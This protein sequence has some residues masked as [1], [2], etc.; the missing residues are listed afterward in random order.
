MKLN[1]HQKKRKITSNPYLTTE[2]NDNNDDW[3]KG[4][5]TTNDDTI[6]KEEQHKNELI[7]YFANIDFMIENESFDNNE[8]EQIFINNIIKEMDRFD[9][10]IFIFEH[11]DISKVIEKII[12]ILP[13]IYIRQFIQKFILPNL[14]PLITKKCSSHVLQTLFSLIPTILIQQQSNHTNNNS[15]TVNTMSDLLVEIIN[16]LK[17]FEHDNNGLSQLFIDEKSTFVMRDLLWISCGVVRFN[18]TKKK[19]R[20]KL[21]NVRKIPQLKKFGLDHVP[22]NVIE[23]GNDIAMNL[24][25]YRHKYKLSTHIKHHKYRRD[26]HS[27]ILC[28]SLGVLIECL[29]ITKTNNILQELIDE[30]LIP[31]P[32]KQKKHMDKN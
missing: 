2:D 5:N 27:N 11:P 18:K 26:K 15:E 29:F 13:S 32:A 19:H 8:N 4:N 17:Q 12:Q 20:M 30:I 25:Q 21:H 24:L 7:D 28:G 6:D 9:D 3:W 14:L 16:K 1:H 22:E 23:F 10:T 31:P